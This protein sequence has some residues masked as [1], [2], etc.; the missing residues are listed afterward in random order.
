MKAL[1]NSTS[2][3]GTGSPGETSRYLAKAGFLDM[4]HACRPGFG[5]LSSTS[6]SLSPATVHLKRLLVFLLAEI[7]KFQTHD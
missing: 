3:K 6:G 4:H 7:C 1:I 2:S 5:V